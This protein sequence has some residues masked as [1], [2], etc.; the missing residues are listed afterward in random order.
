MVVFSTLREDW[1]KNENL[2]RYQVLHSTFT[3]LIY[4]D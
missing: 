2:K 4:D 3:M 1:D